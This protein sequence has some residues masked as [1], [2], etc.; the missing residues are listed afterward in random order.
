MN[1]IKLFKTSTKMDI[2][3]NWHLKDGLSLLI[4]TLILIL[5]VYT[6]LYLVL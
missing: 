5:F 3:L 6:F 1:E 2:I 4:M